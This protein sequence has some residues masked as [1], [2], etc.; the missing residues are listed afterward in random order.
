M[1]KLTTAQIGRSGEIL[2]QYRLL[3]HGIESA[4]MTTDSGIDL[5]AYAP[6]ATRAITIQVKT[7]Q[8]SKAAGGKG[9]LALDWWLVE[10]SPAQLVA[11]VDLENDRAWLFRH[12]ELANKAQQRSGG[13]MHFYFYA[14]PAHTAKRAGTHLSDFTAF[15][16]NNRIENLFGEDAPE[17]SD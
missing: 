7:N 14:D 17:P 15:E 8:Q 11:L 9:R 16:I 10:N 4:P 13:R 6:G 3:K 1:R 12:E 2:V 5:V